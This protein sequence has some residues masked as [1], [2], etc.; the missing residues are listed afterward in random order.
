MQPVSRSGLLRPLG[1]VV[2]VMPDRLQLTSLRLRG[3]NVYEDK[4]EYRQRTEDTEGQRSSQGA[5][6]TEEHHTDDKVR[7]QIRGQHGRSTLGAQT[8]GETLGGVDP[9]ERSVAEVKAHYKEQDTDKSQNRGRS[10]RKSDYE[11][12]VCNHHGAHPCQQGGPAP[13]P[14]N[15]QE[16]DH[17][18]HHA[19]NLDKTVYYDR[20]KRIGDAHFLDNRGAV[21]DDGVDPGDLDQ[22]AK[23]D[24]EETGQPKASLE[25]LAKAALLL[26]GEV[27][28]DSPHLFFGI[29]VALY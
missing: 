22:E 28:F 11:D 10:Q 15:H 21:I 9:H 8:R 26:V 5:E 20:L 29:H 18:R 12:R 19:G 4:R 23:G 16:G 3:Q 13:P 7:Q 14:V 2:P 25:E 27:F 1:A 24:N 17:H 6:R